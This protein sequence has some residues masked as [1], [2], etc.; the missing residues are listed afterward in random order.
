MTFNPDQ[1]RDYHGRWGGGDSAGHADGV[2]PRVLSVIKN[3]PIGFSV[4]V[5]GHQ[6]KSGHMVA[7][8][9]KT[10]I[11]PAK[12]LQGP[13]AQK[14]INDYKLAH[15]D[16]L[17]VPGAHIGGWTKGG[18]TYLD[19]S[20]RIGNKSAAIKLGIA[21]NQIEIWDVKNGKGISTGGTGK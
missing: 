21:R 7:I 11:I 20:Q 10:K 18:K 14:I 13:N 17:S 15:A 3:N 9:G 12:A 16:A 1:P 5:H 2:S 8:Q 19:V 6:P 4:T